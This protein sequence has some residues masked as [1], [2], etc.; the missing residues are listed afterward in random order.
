MSTVSSTSNPYVIS[1]T[2]NDANPAQTAVNKGIE[3]N[4]HQHNL[5]NV[6]KSGGSK[7]SKNKGRRSRGK[8]GKR[9][10]SASL[11]RRK[12]SRK[13]R[14]SL[15]RSSRKSMLRR[16]NKNKKISRGGGDATIT[17]PS[18]SQTSTGGTSIINNLASNHAQ[19]LAYSSFDSDVK[20]PATS[21]AATSTAA[22]STAATSTAATSTGRAAAPSK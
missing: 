8:K 14:K 9:S 3:R 18:F 7:K 19:T 2:I 17:I 22:T 16:R 1:H 20:L 11:S 15:R 5:V 6:S 13:F 10:K 4:M 21:T 12:I